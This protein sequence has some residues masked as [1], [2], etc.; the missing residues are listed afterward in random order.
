VDFKQ[1]RTPAAVGRPRAPLGAG[2]K[3]SARQTGQPKQY[4]AVR[5]EMR[6]RHD[7]EHVLCGVADELRALARRTLETHVTSSTNGQWPE[8]GLPWL[9]CRR[10]VP[11]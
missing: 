7:G 6:L 1:L 9:C 2:G 8:C 5:A 4:L 10:E 11:W 3:G